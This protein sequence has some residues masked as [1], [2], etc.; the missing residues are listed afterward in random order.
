MIKK[1]PLLF[2]ALAIICSTTNVYS[3][4]KQLTVVQEKA[5]LFKER[6]ISSP[7][8]RYL[9]K[10][11]KVNL[12]SAEDSFYLV[13]YG[14]YEGWVIP[15]SVVGQDSGDSLTE[16]KPD[17]EITDQ[18]VEI[19]SDAEE[20]EPQPN[21]SSDRYLIV[22]NSYANVREGPGLNY[23][24]VGRAYQGEKL[25]KFIKRGRW[26]RVRLPN[27]LIGFYP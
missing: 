3:Q 24:M 18:Q 2:L 14:G 21:L 9:E 15:Y 25:E 26:Y 11:S 4:T 6:S 7:I 19:Q 5:P 12:L 27:S 1:L 13:S 8:I 23:K 17:T 16:S 10:G 22:I 20:S